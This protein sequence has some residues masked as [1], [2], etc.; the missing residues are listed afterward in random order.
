MRV[1]TNNGIY[2][3]YNLILTYEIDD[4]PF[5]I[6]IAQD[7]IREFFGCEAIELF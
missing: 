4:H 2:P 6:M 5:D 3:D 7:K 1:Y